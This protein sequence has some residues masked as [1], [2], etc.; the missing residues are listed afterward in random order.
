MNIRRL[1][2]V[3]QRGLTM[4]AA[5]NMIERSD[6][7]P[8]PGIWIDGGLYY[9]EVVHPAAESPIRVALHGIRTPQQACEAL[10][11]FSGH[12]H[13]ASARAERL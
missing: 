3:R 13:R 8:L 10:T 6:Y 11:V 4:S 9:T 2:A 12:G 7:P 5:L 1:N